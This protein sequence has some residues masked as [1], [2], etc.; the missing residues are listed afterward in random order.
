M[1]N[2]F[3]GIDFGGTKINFAVL[4]GNKVTKQIKI[5]TG[6]VNSVNDIVRKINE[7]V[8]LIGSDNFVAIGIGI[9]G[10]VDQVRGVGVYLTNLGKLR[11][12]PLAKVVS[13]EFSTPVYID[14]DVDVALIAESKLGNL[15]GVSNAVFISVGT[16]VGG[17]ILISHKVYIGKNG[18]AGEIGHV[19]VRQNGLKCN[20]GKKGC[21]ETESSGTAIERY[22]R[23]RIK[24]GRKT[25][26]DKIDAK[27]IAFFAKHGD[28]L[29]LEAFHN[30]ARYL[31]LTS[32]NLINVFNPEKV[33]LGGGLIE[34]G[35]ILNEVRKLVKKY[36]LP[37]FLKEVSIEESALKN[38]AGAIGAA[39]LA[40]ERFSGKNIYIY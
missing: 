14:N 26:I 36:A 8:N 16:G 37:M 13:N 27:R 15:K 22:V 29:A 3:L 2:K 17:A 31:A 6:K 10:M 21:L 11:N 20:C 9:A 25:S 12:V 40:M 19:T 7:G 35:L 28:T 1:N 39:L 32:G 5:A 4:Q 33:I 18:F 38:N 34:S 23:S 24:R 30:A